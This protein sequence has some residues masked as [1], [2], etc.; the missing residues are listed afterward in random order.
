[1]KEYKCF[2]RSTATYPDA[3][4]NTLSE[5]MYLALGLSGEA[6]EVA[7]HVKR[8]YCSAPLD[9]HALRSELGDVLWYLVRLADTFSF[10][11][12]EIIEANISKL[13]ERKANGSIHEH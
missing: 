1:M 5:V 12:E 6:G 10:S 2:T 3:L 4:S 11:I 13:S 7:E 9:R 8:L